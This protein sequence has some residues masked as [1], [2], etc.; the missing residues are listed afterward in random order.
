MPNGGPGAVAFLSLNNLVS[1]RLLTIPPV[2]VCVNICKPILPQTAG[3]DYVPCENHDSGGKLGQI[4]AIYDP[5]IEEASVKITIS[6]KLRV[7]II[8]RGPSF[9]PRVL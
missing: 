5:V 7:V 8:Y 9:L 2:L 3:T 6:S 4:K 1:S